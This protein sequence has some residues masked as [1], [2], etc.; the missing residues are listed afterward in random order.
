M[1]DKYDTEFPPLS[2]QNKTLKMEMVAL[3][4]A[5]VVGGT[6]DTQKSNLTGE[7]SSPRGSLSSPME[8]T[9]GRTILDSIS[10]R[11][12]GQASRAGLQYGRQSCHGLV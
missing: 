7:S 12:V 1:D 5:E 3:R 11:G 2:T 9:E 4:R 8:S 6:T 10:C